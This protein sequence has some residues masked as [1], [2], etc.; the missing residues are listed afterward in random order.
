MKNSPLLLIFTLFFLILKISFSSEFIALETRPDVTQ[1]F[2]LLKSE[3]KAKASV[4]LISGGKGKIKIQNNDGD[5]SIGKEGNFLVRT[6]EYFA[7][8]GLNVA[9]IDAPSDQYDKD[10]MFFGFRDSEEHMTDLKAVVDYLKQK[11]NL[12]VW[13]IGTSRGTESTANA[14]I[15]LNK[16]LQ[17]IVLTSSITEESAK[18]TTLINMNLDIITIPTLIVAHSNDACW[19]TPPEGAEAI[20]NALTKASV[21][22]VKMFNGG[23]DPIS[24]P[25]K[26]KSQHGFLGIEEDVVKY[27]GSFVKK[28]SH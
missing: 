21:V 20:K 26:A 4:I 1:K 8:Q 19:V 22:E 28:H 7:E 11:F 3:T 18:G 2:A 27:I 15:T 13:V 16:Q 23:D 5:A 9:V 17:G 14:A 12:P 24:K 10:G 6:R 25:C